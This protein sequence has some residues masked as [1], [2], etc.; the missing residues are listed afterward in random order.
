MADRADVVPLPVG[1]KARGAAQF[2]EPA[3]YFVDVEDP[4]RALS[5]TWSP[6]HT[7]V[8]LGIEAADGSPTALVLHAD[9]VLDLVRALVVGLP[10]HG[11]GCPHPPATVVPLER[12][13]RPR[14][15]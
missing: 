9:E 5:V 12:P 7:V 15:D 11:T 10:E 6:D 14:A 2:P 13:G 1:R 8:Q 3:D 4:A